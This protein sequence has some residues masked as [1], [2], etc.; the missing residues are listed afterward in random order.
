MLGFKQMIKNLFGKDIKDMTD[1]ELVKKVETI[2]KS[3]DSQIL[4][5]NIENSNVAENKVDNNDEIVDLDISNFNNEDAFPD[6]EFLEYVDNRYTN[7]AIERYG[8]QV[9]ADHI[10]AG[11]LIQSTIEESLSLLTLPELKDILKTHN[12]ILSG[13]KQELIQRIILNLD[14][15]ELSSIEL[16]SKLYLSNLGE[17]AL[18]DFVDAKNKDRITRASRIADLILSKQFK[19][20][21]TIP[22]LSPHSSFSD[23]PQAISI[24]IHEL[25]ERKNISIFDN[26]LSL[27]DKKTIMALIEYTCFG[28]SVSTIANDIGEDVNLE[29]M[30]Y[31]ANGCYA[32]NNAL[33]FYRC[34]A[35]YK[36]HSCSCCE[37]C[38]KND[39]KIFS[40]S[41]AKIEKTLPPFSENCRAFI[42]M[43]SDE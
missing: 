9:I 28:C 25:E 36:I 26:H 12:L 8:E 30:I 40:V 42:T 6:Y 21:S 37:K 32:Y 34:G 3:P 4:L 18:K 20:A 33:G 31:V 16:P 5:D 11:Y 10:E 17:K 2:A 38:K 35:K 14:K 7:R 1:E 39:G 15:T 19:Q 22:P 13:K 29:T 23:M 43:A 27:L 24:C 41:E